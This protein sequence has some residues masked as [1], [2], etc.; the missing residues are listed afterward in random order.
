MFIGDALYFGDP[1]GNT[2]IQD[3]YKDVSLE[4]FKSIFQ[5][6]IRYFNFMFIFSKGT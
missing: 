5:Q 6:T 4:H 3:K 1:T 2:T